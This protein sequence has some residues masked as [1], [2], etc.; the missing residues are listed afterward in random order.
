LEALHRPAGRLHEWSV[1]GDDVVLGVIK[2]A[3][4]VGH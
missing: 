1:M 4:L 3:N 2:E